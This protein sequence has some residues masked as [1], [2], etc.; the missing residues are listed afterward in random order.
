M[1]NK[2]KFVILRK[3][4]IL[5]NSVL[6]TGGFDVEWSLKKIDSN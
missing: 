3:L 1:S 5:K 2:K 6:E 4:Y